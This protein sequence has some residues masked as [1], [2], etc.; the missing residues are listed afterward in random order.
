MSQSA[1]LSTR[2]IEWPPPS[3]AAGPRSE[4]APAKRLAWYELVSGPSS[5]LLAGTA[6]G[7]TGAFP[8]MPAVAVQHG[9]YKINDMTHIMTENCPLKAGMATVGGEEFGRSENSF[10]LESRIL[11]QPACRSSPITFCAFRWLYGSFDGRLHGWFQYECTNPANTECHGYASGSLSPD[12]HQSTRVQLLEC[13]W[14]I[15][16]HERFST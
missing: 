5:I 12:A 1:D 9:D 4:A 2:N 3:P 13:F 7:P 6:L 8:L 14:M 10:L 16:L 11:I 15:R